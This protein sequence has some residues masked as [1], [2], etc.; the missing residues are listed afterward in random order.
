MDID[1]A[2]NDVVYF[3]ENVLGFTLQEWQ[4]YLL[5]KYE[6]GEIIWFGGHRYG[7]NMVKETI[8][9]HQKFMS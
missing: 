8:R 4:K 1:K 6:Q 7:K 3:A 5:R 2:K 9:E